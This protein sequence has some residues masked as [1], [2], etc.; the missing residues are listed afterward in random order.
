MRALVFCSLILTTTPLGADEAPAS[1]PAYER[2]HFKERT[3]EACAV[4]QVTVAFP[5]EGGRNWSLDGVASE[6]VV[7]CDKVPVFQKTPVPASVLKATEMEEWRVYSSGIPEQVEL[8][9]GVPHR[10]LMIVAVGPKANRETTGPCHEPLWEV[11]CEGD[12]E[13]GAAVSALRESE[14]LVASAELLL[15]SGDR[16]K[17]DP[18]LSQLDGLIPV[19]REGLIAMPTTLTVKT[20]DGGL[21]SRKEFAM[22]IVRVLERMVAIRKSLKGIK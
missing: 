22:R 10:V 12:D 8:V 1:P 3:V 17:L 13:Y 2:D 7:A 11:T 6:F 5:V 16:A 18:A 15:K 21:Q 20:S 14:P 4:R 19:M 9:R